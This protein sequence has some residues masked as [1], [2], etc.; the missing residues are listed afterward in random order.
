MLINR[1]R[2]NSHTSIKKYCWPLQGVEN[3]VI[4]YRF[5]YTMLIHEIDFY[6]QS[7][8]RITTPRFPTAM[9]EY[10]YWHNFYTYYYY[11]YYYLKR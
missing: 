5:R 3:V 2:V 1:K 6:P 11:Y 9:D 10:R 8:V 4:G 7:L